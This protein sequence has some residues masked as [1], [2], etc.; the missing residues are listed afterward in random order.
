[1]A[2]TAQAQVH[3][4]QAHAA[5]AAQ[6]AQAAQVQ[7][8]ADPGYRLQVQICYPLFFLIHLLVSLAE[9]PYNHDLT[10]IE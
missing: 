1:M 6:A 7:M 9:R 8:P 10:L 4:V 2:A 5:H 3:A